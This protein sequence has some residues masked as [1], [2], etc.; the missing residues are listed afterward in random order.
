MG[1]MDVDSSFENVVAE[2][3]AQRAALVLGQVRIF[4][5]A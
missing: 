1:P 3:A 5:S 4:Q 2:T